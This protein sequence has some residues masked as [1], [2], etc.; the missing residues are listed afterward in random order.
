MTVHGWTVYYVGGSSGGGSINIFYRNTCSSDVISR[1]IVTSR[2][3]FS[4][5]TTNGGRGTSTLT[6]VIDSRF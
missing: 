3:N 2:V 1:A 5:K 4:A 6:H